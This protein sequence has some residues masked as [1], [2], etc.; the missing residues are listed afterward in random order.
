MNRKKMTRVWPGILIVGFLFSPV[1]AMAQIAKCQDADG[2]WHYGNFASEECAQSDITHMDGSGNVLG[3]EGR[4]LTDEELA[5]AKAA[6]EREAELQALRDSE[7]AERTRIA[8]T[9]DTEED[10]ARARDNKLQT[11]EQQLATVDSLLVLRR[12]RLEQVTESLATARPEATGMIERLTSEQESL[13]SQVLEYEAAITEAELRKV[14]IESNY[15]RELKIYRE[16][17]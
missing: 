12:N 1:G 16:F 11:V 8:D 15:I 13:T 5:Q 7:L 3:R 4:P 6:S 14:E 10:I 17:N 2:E 9:Y